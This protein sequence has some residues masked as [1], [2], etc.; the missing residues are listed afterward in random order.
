MAHNGVLPAGPSSRVRFLQT[1]RADGD[2]AIGAL[3]VEA[4]RAALV[5]EPWTWLE[6]VHGAT[7]VHVAH[8][9]AGA[10][11]AADA[12]VTTQVGAPLCVQT[13]DCVPLVLAGDGVVAVAHAGWRGLL[14]GVIDEAAAAVRSLAD[15]R[16]VRAWRGP[17]IG[18]ECYAFGADD[19]APLADRFGPTVV[20]HTSRGLRALDLR[21]ATA[22]ALAMADIELVGADERCTACASATCFSH[23]ARGDH[24]RHTLVAWLEAAS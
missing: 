8:A 13:A 19:L 4:R 14:A 17:C 24:G 1:D 10:G 7:V 16:A 5:G 6:Q 20:G 18:P 2:F 12:A 23:R 21:A 22:A 11:D 9:G 3:G 15:G